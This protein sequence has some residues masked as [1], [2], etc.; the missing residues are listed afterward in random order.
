MRG[1]I[2]SAK[3]FKRFFGEIEDFNRIMTELESSLSKKLVTNNE[4]YYKKL[5]KAMGK[6]VQKIN[7]LEKHIAGSKELLL[8]SKNAFRVLSGKLFDKSSILKHCF[9]KPQGYPGDY[10]TMERFYDGRP[11][12]RGIG[13]LLDRYYLEGDGP[14]AIRCRKEAILNIVTD[15]I[16]N[17]HKKIS[18]IDIGCGSCRIE[19]ELIDLVGEQVFSKIVFVD[20]DIDALS[21]SKKI[22]EKHVEKCKM[23]FQ[24]MDVISLLRRSQLFTEE[25]FD[26]IFCIGLF[27][28][29]YDATFGRLVKYLWRMLAPGG[30]IVLSNCSLAHLNR[31][32]REWI[33]DWR[34]HHRSKEQIQGILEQTEIQDLKFKFSMERS[35]GIIIITLYKR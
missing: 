34:M 31:T 19:K 8:F 28:Y 2:Q 35:N 1:E 29:I 17:S 12:G 26:V 18:L 21:F 32:E 27:D 22:N 4:V 33:V 7:C 16:K 20:Q 30:M 24:Q 23:R 5:C 10:I 25:K 6:L 3:A 11:R 9:Y 15:F 14:Q 13:R